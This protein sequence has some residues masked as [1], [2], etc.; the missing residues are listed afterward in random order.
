ME[1]FPVKVPVQVRFRDLDALGHVNNA[2]YLTYFE[3]ARVAYFSR[4]ERD[5]VGRGHFI[6]ARAEVDFLRPIHLEDPVEVGVRVVRIGCS[7]FDMEYRVEVRG[8]EAARGR[9]VQVWLEG[10][11]PAPLP[12][13]IRERIRALEGRPL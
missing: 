3:V 6:L 7:S 9:T 2:V 8:E 4:L 5:W 10:G 13:A 11:S 1:G 12:E